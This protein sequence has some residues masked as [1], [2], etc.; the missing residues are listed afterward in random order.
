MSNG[1]IF[2]LLAAAAADFG[3]APANTLDPISRTQHLR[4]FFANCEFSGIQTDESDPPANTAFLMEINTAGWICADAR[5]LRNVSRTRIYDENTP[6]RGE[7]VSEDFTDVIELRWNPSAS[8]IQSHLKIIN[9]E[10]WFAGQIPLKEIKFEHVL[11]YPTNLGRDSS[12]FWN[13]LLLGEFI[14]D[15]DFESGI[16]FS[17]TVTDG[18][19]RG[20]QFKEARWAKQDRSVVVYRFSSWEYGS[21]AAIFSKIRGEW[22]PTRYE[23]SYGPD[24]K[25]FVPKADFDNRLKNWMAFNDF[26]DE[27]SSLDRLEIVYEVVYSDLPSSIK[28]T[29]KRYSH[30]KHSVV[31]SELVFHKLKPGGVTAAMVVEASLPLPDGTEVLPTDDERKSLRW[32]MQDQKIVKSIDR[33]GERIGQ[34]AKFLSTRTTGLLLTS[35]IITI[36]AALV[37]YRRVI[38]S[39]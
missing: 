6:L 37:I 38:L 16:T 28:K 30:G 15:I 1:L 32:V 11:S 31:T 20:F 23:L 35:L 21:C 19:R 12:P 27:L 39:Q 33:E 13:S 25:T 4:K 2:C 17:D 36:L 26:G 14:S 34:S 10:R 8:L 7:K 3:A 5:L 24:D 22:L 29:E 18:G 9:P